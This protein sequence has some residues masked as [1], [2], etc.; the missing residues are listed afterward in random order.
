MLATDI[1]TETTKWAN[2]LFCSVQ[3]PLWL[4]DW[5]HSLL[6]Y[7]QNSSIKLMIYYCE[8][9]SALLKYSLIILEI[10]HPIGLIMFTPGWN[11]S[12]PVK[13]YPFRHMICSILS[14]WNIIVLKIFYWYFSEKRSYLKSYQFVTEFEILKVMCWIFFM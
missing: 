10:I 3:L 11:S 8:I 12:Y 2:C 1:I 9:S 13:E 6:I 7:H 5:I 14:S 4:L